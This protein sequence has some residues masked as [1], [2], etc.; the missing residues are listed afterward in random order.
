MGEFLAASAF[1]TQNAEA[2]CAAV[3]QFFSDNGYPAQRVE[4]GGLRDLSDEDTVIHDSLGGWSV[5][6]WPRYMQDGPAVEVLTAKLATTASSIRVHD[7]DY[8]VHR[9]VENGRT[10]DRFASMPD[11][12]AEDPT[13]AETAQLAA[14]WAGQ[15]RALAAA[16]GVAESDIAPYL[17]Q[18]PALD[19]EDE[20]EDED[21]ED[22]EEPT[23]RWGK[24]FTDDAYDRSNVWVFVD[25]WR[26]IGITYPAPYPGSTP[27]APGRVLR[28]PPGASLKLPAGTD[29]L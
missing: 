23:D 24:A 29:E 8:W 26:R 17:V 18:A 5:V 4:P 1:R 25:F 15:P 2:L 22:F 7:G 19:V 20:D 27:A 28:L 9:L 13:S 12:F 16:F 10:L 14:E 21:E 3:A 6:T 11:Y